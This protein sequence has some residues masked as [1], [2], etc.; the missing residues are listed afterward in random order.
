M[1]PIP[2]VSVLTTCYNREAYLAATIESVLSQSFTDYEYII[3]DDCSADSTHEIAKLY[4]KKDSRIRV[5]KN[6]NNLGDYPNRN[7]AASLAQG[8]YLKYLDSD[9]L[10][11]P[12][13]LDVMVR[14]MEEHPDAG[15]GLVKLHTQDRPLPSLFNPSESYHEHFLGKGLFGNA[16]GSAIIHRMRFESL[17]QFSGR[18]YIGDYECWMK[19]ASHFPLVL[20]PGFLGWDRKHGDQESALDNVEYEL[21]RYDT[22]KE[23]LFS[24]ECPVSGNERDKFIDVM[25]KRIGRYIAVLWLR[26]RTLQ[27]GYRLFRKTGCNIGDVLMGTLRRA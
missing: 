13:C 12:H 6:E 21:L 2:T 10:M 20:I 16:P 25:H 1:T 17:G 11:Y 27:G 26:Q 15:L 5:Y 19:L 8:K 3:V 9:D 23:A 7:K 14:C 22:A 18:R 4:E 24:I